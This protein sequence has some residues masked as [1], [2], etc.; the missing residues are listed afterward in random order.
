MS[1]FRFATGVVVCGLLIS[2][3]S[4]TSK[5]KTIETETAKP[6][7][8]IS[9]ST[10]VLSEGQIMDRYNITD[11]NSAA[12]ALRV[13]LDESLSPSESA[14]PTLASC[15]MKGDDAKKLLMP[16]K[17]LMDNQISIERDAYI[18][19]PAEYARTH[20]LESCAAQCACGTMLS[21][22]EPVDMSAI[23]KAKDKS[24]H[25]RYLK[26]MEAKAERQ[27]ADESATCARKA[28]WFCSSDLRSYLEREASKNAQ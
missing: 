4:C 25:K 24:Q 10:L 23:K 3:T 13:I 1:R 15:K 11:T 12:N 9:S 18:N 7:G 19:D 22:L 2:I 8:P 17:A 6:L 26:H 14:E 21:I 5:D 16:L 28:A 20:P 27:S